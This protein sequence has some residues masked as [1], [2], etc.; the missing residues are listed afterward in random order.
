MMPKVSSSTI[1]PT[2][3]HRSEALPISLVAQT[4]LAQDKRAFWRPDPASSRFA[5]WPSLA[6]GLRPPCAVRKRKGAATIARGWSG[7]VDAAYQIKGRLILTDATQPLFWFSAI[8]IFA[9]LKSSLSSGR[10]SQDRNKLS[11]SRCPVR[12]QSCRRADKVFR[13]RPRRRRS[14]LARKPVPNIF[15]QASSRF[16]NIE[17][18]GRLSPFKRSTKRSTVTDCHA[19]PVGGD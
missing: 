11:V 12:F 6:G 4:E 16:V 15:T 9:F 5:R 13:R 19:L 18:H 3:T 8:G 1:V 17:R 7:P 2:C 10:D 14:C